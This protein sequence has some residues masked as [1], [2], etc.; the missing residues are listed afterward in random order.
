MLVRRG[1]KGEG[2]IWQGFDPPGLGLVLSVSATRRS[3]LT[4][5][6]EG[7]GRDQQADCSK[8][9]ARTGLEQICEAIGHSGGRTER[10]LAIREGAAGRAGSPKPD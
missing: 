4:R 2:K 1:I 7:E 9:H 6:D 10:H 5:G 3:F 8:R